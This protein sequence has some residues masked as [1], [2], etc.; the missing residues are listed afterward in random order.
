MEKITRTIETKKATAVVTDTATLQTRTQ[1]YVVPGSCKNEKQILKGIEKQLGETEIAVS[2]K[3]VT[4]ESHKY[5][6][7]LDQFVEL[8]TLAE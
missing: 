8:A 2:V 1:D 5:E 6:M 7:P 3:D 4:T